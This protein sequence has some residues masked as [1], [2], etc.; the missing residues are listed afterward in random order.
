MKR[1]ISRI[2]REWKYS[3][4]WLHSDLRH[5]PIARSR[6]IKLC[7]FAN[8]LLGECSPLA[9]LLFIDLW[10][11]A[12]RGGRLEERPNRMRGELLPYDDKADVDALLAE[13]SRS[14]FI[15]GYQVYD[16]PLIAANFLKHQNPHKHEKDSKLPPPDQEDNQN[17]HHT[18]TVLA[19]DKHQ[20]STVVAR[21]IPDS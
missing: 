18:C 5:R 4:H 15:V 9:R 12:D 2:C 11:L 17:E 7:F 3:L 1:P 21:L 8:D 16:Q 13:L 6:N 14:G 20:A 10:T 19:P